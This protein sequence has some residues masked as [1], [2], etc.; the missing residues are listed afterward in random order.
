MAVNH[1][2]WIKFGSDVPAERIA[3]HL[4]GLQSLA[5]SVPGIRQLTVGRNFTNRA[6][7]YTHGVSVIL[8][9]EAALSAYA[10]HPRHVEVAT[11]LRKDSELM[12]LD[13]VY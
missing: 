12:A 1:M 8:D 7:G 5:T 2:V 9:D 3:Q 13:Y 6:N 11:A 10:V 4:A